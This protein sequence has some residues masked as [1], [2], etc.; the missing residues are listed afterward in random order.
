MRIHQRSVSACSTP[1]S[2]RSRGVSEGDATVWGVLIGRDHPAAVLGAEISRAA[3]SHGGLVLVTG[4]AGIGKTTL[5]TRAVEQAR[6]SGA[7]VLSGA[8]WDSGSAPGYWPWTQVVRGLR[9]GATPEEWAAADEVAGDG[10]AVLLGDAAAGPAPEGFLLYD[11]VTSALVAVSQHRPVVVVLDDLHWADTASLRLLEFAAQHTWFE[12]LLLIGTYRDA[13]VEAA[14]HP[15]RPLLMPLVARATTVSLT[16]LTR[17]EVGALMAQTVGRQPDDALVTEVHRRTG[18]NP[19]FVEQTARLWHSGGTV[20][21]I[22]PGVRDALRRRLSLLPPPV[23]GVL[24]TAAVLGR[25][26]HRQVLAAS[27]SMPVPHADRLLDQAVAA[28]LVVALGGGRFAF[29]HDLVRETLYGELDEAAARAQHAAV[30]RAVERTPALAAALVP[31]DGARHAYLAC[32]DLPAEQVV[33]LLLAAGRDAGSRMASDEAIGHHRRAYERAAH[34]DPRRRVVI[35]LHLASDLHHNDL[36]GFWPIIE[37]AAGLARQIGDPH[38]LARVA[39]TLHRIDSPNAPRDLALDLLGEVHRALTGEDPTEPPDRLVPSLA[40]RLADAARDSGD[41]DSLG[42]ALWALHDAVWGP[43]TAVDRAALTEE[44]M[45][46]ARRLGDRGMEY[47]AASFRWVALL[48][49]GDPAYLDQYRAFLTL[50]A[51]EGR[52]RSAFASAVDTSIIATM[53]GRFADAEA[54]LDK[55]V[56]SFA[57]HSHPHFQ[58]VAGHLRWATWL[59]QGRFDDLAAL[60]PGLVEAGHPHVDMLAG[61]VAAHSGDSGTALAHLTTMTASGRKPPRDF[62]PMWLRFQAQVAAASDDEALRERAHAALAPYRGE[63]LVSLYGCDVGGPA[64]LWLGVLDAA[65][66]RHDEAVAALTAAAESAD[67]LQS[68]PWSVESRAHLAHVLLDRDAPGDAKAAATLIDDVESE[69]ADMGMRHVVERVRRLRTEAPA[70]AP[71]EFRRDGAVWSL[72]YAG[73]HAHMPDAKGLH[74]LRHLLGHP[75]TDIP[76]VLLLSPEGGAVAVAVGRMGGDDILDDEAKAHY[77]RRLSQLDDEIDRAA[78]RGDDARATEGAAGRQ[79]PI[80]GARAGA[81]RGGRSR[82]FG[83][84]AERARK[85]VTARI[86][87]TLRRLDQVHP[88]LA[89]HLRETISTGATCAYSPPAPTQWRL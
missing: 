13:E 75:G 24:A 35:A 53:T 89:T 3:G 71:N 2:R 62:T 88:A 18:G 25:E 42:L 40:L 33:D 57:E 55:A 82:R 11:A 4:E 30:V 84:E 29:A 67:R 80:G 70:P 15:V 79:P 72:R 17:D 77:K 76:A 7:L 45:A 52:P 56:Q 22:A 48:E 73:A 28:R 59:L 83:D 63:W 21:A 85:T 26:F 6:E 51:R 64:D 69:A 19:F 74:D 47:F 68:R 78:A 65:S 9:R 16:G 32:D 60:H 86:R 54:A 23:A 34:A 31:A 37:E 39:L 14:E 43:G 38:L 50:T 87:D 81:G 5:V 41:D 27:A 36:T 10:L 49:R 1:V 66:G 20:T 12:R 8:C 44:L 46:V 58:Y 61:I